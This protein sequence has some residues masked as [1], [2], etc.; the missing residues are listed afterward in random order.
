M[1][2]RKLFDQ[3]GAPAPAS[4]LIS[5]ALL[6][7]LAGCASLPPA[8]FTE[9]VQ[10][11]ADERHVGDAKTQ[12]VE[13]LPC[14]RMDAALLDRLD[15]VLKDDDLARAKPEALAILDE[16]HGLAL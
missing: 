9:G 13:G 7:L 15:A 3:R 12:R 11:V 10:W 2:C 6:A 14:L 16:A 1:Y 8:R 5:M 4:A